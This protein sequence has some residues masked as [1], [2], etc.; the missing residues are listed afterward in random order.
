MLCGRRGALT[1][2]PRLY[3]ALMP[4]P[5]AGR[6]CVTTCGHLEEVTLTPDLS[7]VT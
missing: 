2:P 5:W 3:R 4:L 1:S 6:G 7:D